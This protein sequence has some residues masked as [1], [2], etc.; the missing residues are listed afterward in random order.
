MKWYHPSMKLRNSIRIILIHEQQLLLMCADDPKSRSA[1]GISYGRHWFLIGGEIEQGETF[2]QA[3]A[4]E[5]FEETGLKESDVEFGPVVWFGEFD[6]ILFGTPTRMKQ[7]F[8]VAKTKNRSVSLDHL[9]PEEKKV[10]QKLEWFTLEQIRH[11][12]EV[13]FPVVLKDYFPA[14]LQGQFPPA[15]IELDL[16]KKPE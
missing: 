15:P 7:Q 5:L 8:I 12:K 9:T 16:G 3:A 13:I 2:L 14:I 6:M 10:I 11:S 4:R 1:E